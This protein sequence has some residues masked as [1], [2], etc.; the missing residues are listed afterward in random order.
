MATIKLGKLPDRTPVKLTINVSPTLHRALEKYA[1]L[2]EQVHGTQEPLSELVP[3]MLSAF[4]ESDR[5][6]ARRSTP[7]L[8]AE[9]HEG[10]AR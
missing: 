6:F 8:V 4:L 10:G 2:Y 5:F 3:A 1:L 7:Q 9:A